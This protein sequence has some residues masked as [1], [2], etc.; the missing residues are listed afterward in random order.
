VNQVATARQSN[1]IIIIDPQVSL[2]ALS[3]H[4]RHLQTPASPRTAAI[5][6]FLSNCA[7]NPEHLRRSIICP[8]SIPSPS[9]V[10]VRRFKHGLQLSPSNRLTTRRT[11]RQAV[12]EITPVDS[13]VSATAPFK[14]YHN[15]GRSAYHPRSQNNGG[16]EKSSLRCGIAF[17]ATFS[18]DHEVD[19]VVRGRGSC[20]VFCASVL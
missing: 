18:T 17:A 3:D 15:L 14:A 4:H 13:T 1:F 10:A 20:P 12:L 7:L 2:K 8:L 11:D 6:L 19:D 16:C 5:N 9:S